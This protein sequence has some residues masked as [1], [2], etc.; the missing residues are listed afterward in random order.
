MRCTNVSGDGIEW[1]R[2]VVFQFAAVK[3]DFTVC[4][5]PAD[6]SH[7]PYQLT[8]AMCKAF[9]MLPLRARQLQ[10]L[11]VDWAKSSGVCWDRKGAIGNKLKAVHWAMLVAAF[12]LYHVDLIHAGFHTPIELGRLLFEVVRFYA[13]F[14]FHNFAIAPL[15]AGKLRKPPF[16]LRGDQC[17]ADKPYI[18]LLDPMAF[19]R[20]NRRNFATWVDKA[21][22]LVLQLELC[23]AGCQLEH[24][25]QREAYFLQASCNWAN[26]V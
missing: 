8:C 4:F 22:F 9:G 2:T 11:T 13:H 5:G 19:S 16:V 18:Q 25:F 24:T 26:I 15:S 7:G 17:R 20:G 23:R 21:G 10:R 1:K 14:E 12:W 6:S 3:V